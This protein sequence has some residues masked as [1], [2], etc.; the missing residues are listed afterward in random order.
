MSADEVHANKMAVSNARAEAHLASMPNDATR[1]RILLA[2][3]HKAPLG[4]RATLD[5]DT[6]E[7]VRLGCLPSALHAVPAA[8]AA[9]SHLTGEAAH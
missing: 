3:K 6:T 7:Q 2:A 5:S 8:V 1:S 9:P 4:F